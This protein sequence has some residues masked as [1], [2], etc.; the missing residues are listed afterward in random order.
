MTLMLLTMNKPE[1]RQLRQCYLQWINQSDVHDVN[2]EHISHY[3]LEL[4]LLNLNTEFFAKMLMFFFNE[5]KCTVELSQVHPFISNVRKREGH[6][7]LYL[8]HICFKSSQF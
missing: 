1:R 5:E 6:K 7:V 2:F 3:L 8:L 4:L